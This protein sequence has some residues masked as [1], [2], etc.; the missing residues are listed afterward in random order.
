VKTFIVDASLVFEAESEEHA[1]EQFLD[2]IGVL[3]NVKEEDV[4]KFVKCVIS[5][6]SIMLWQSKGDNSDS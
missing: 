4:D 6:E 1:V 5:A 2:S 3:A